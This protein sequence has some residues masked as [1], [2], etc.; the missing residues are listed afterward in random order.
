MNEDST[1]V[2]DDRI[3]RIRETPEDQR[4]GEDM[5]ILGIDNAITAAQKA[6]VDAGFELDHLVLVFDAASSP[7]KNPDTPLMGMVVAPHHPECA[8]P[9]LGGAIASVLGENPELARLL[10]GGGGAQSGPIH[11]Q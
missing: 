2:T 1:D 3:Q 8:V 7:D 10:E 6:M 9:L 5:A 11:H 4:T